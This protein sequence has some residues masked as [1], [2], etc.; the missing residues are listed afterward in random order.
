MVG[1]APVSSVASVKSHFFGRLKSTFVPSLVLMTEP[2]DQES[3]EMA[4][5][6][7]DQVI[8]EVEATAP[9]VAQAIPQ[10][11]EQTAAQSQISMGTSKAKETVESAASP[12]RVTG[13]AIGSGPIEIEPSK[14]LEVPVEVESYLQ[15]V[16]ENQDQ[17]PQEIVVADDGANFTT[18]DYPKTPVIVLPI[19]PEIEQAGAK[20][21]PQ[22]SIRWLIEWS[23]KLM[24]V[25]SGMVIYRQVETN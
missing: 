21:S 24:K 8:S 13:D 10:V 6:T 9:L 7:L 18:R 22:F 20:K 15:K 16:A 4:L 14:E 23:R 3:E 25:F 19:T 11:L 5:D 1:A 17:L 12:D 2:P